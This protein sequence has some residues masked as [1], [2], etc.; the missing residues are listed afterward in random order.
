MYAK[1]TQLQFQVGTTDEAARIIR[2]VMLPNASKQRGFKG[3]FL[4]RHD[5]DPDKHIVIS[6]WESK[7]DL[8]ASRPPEEIIPLLAPLDGYIIESEQDTCDVLLALY[9]DEEQ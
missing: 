2:E 7:A 1:A 8:L 9:K 3:A 5:S 6:L 4:L